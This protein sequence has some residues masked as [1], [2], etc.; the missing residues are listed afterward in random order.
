M[1]TNKNLEDAQRQSFDDIDVNNTRQ[2]VTDS[3]SQSKLDQI[4]SLLGGSSGTPF[5]REN[6]T[7]TIPGST[8]TLINEIVG[9]GKTLT[10]KR[11]TISCSQSVTYEVKI[12]STI[13]GSGR[14]G[15]GNLDSSFVFDVDRTATAGQ[16]VTVTILT[17]TGR[18]ASDVEA[19]LQALEQ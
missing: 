7:V 1:S 5:F 14:V 19:Y 18:P 8:Q 11:V 6:Q 4:I 9:V 3:I 13:V 12:D 2:K 10:I 17:Q 16:A 15:P